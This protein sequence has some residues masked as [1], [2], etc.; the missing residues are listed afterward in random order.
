MILAKHSTNVCANTHP[1]MHTPMN[2]RHTYYMHT[3]GPPLLSIKT[4]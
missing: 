2:A 1:L 4:F 3:H